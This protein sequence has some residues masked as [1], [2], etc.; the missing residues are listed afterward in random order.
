MSGI[1]G[2]T[3]DAIRPIQDLFTYHEVG[4]KESHLNWPA[5]LTDLAE[6][7]VEPVPPHFMRVAAPRG[8]TAEDFR[9][10]W[11]PTQEKLLRA[12]RAEHRRYLKIHQ[13]RVI[14]A[15][16]LKRI[17]NGWL[18]VIVITSRK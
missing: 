7:T 4:R 6:T 15:R 3:M 11:L 16:Q 1:V 12:V 5:L 9:D 2:H 14:E 13:R 8:G 17:G 10:G 18:K